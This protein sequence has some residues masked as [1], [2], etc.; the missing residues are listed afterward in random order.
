MVDFI[1]QIW[2]LDVT[3]LRELVRGATQ[4]DPLEIGAWH[5]APLDYESGMPTT[6]GLYRVRGTAC[7]PRRATAWSLI[8]KIVVSNDE[9]PTAPYYWKREFLLDSVEQVSLRRTA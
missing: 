4:D 9:G 2:D 6:G 7:G 8:C 3:T 5:V 1:D